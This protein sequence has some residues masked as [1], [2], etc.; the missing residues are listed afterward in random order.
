M[1]NEQI[2]QVGALSSQV[3][4]D[5]FVREGSKIYDLENRTLAFAKRVISF[6]NVVERTI[7]NKEIGKQLVRSAGSVGQLY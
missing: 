3:E 2:F 1:S 5:T 4:D 7:A 6:I